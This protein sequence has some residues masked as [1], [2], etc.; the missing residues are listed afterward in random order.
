[1]MTLLQAGHSLNAQRVNFDRD[2]TLSFDGVSTD[3]RTLNVGQLFFAL[4]GPNFDGHDVLAQARDRGAVAAVVSRQVD[5]VLPQ[6]LVS[7]TRLA[8]GQLAGAWRQ[9]FKGKLIA[10]TGSNGKTTVKEMLASILACKGEVLATAGNFNNDIGMPLTLLR[11]RPEQH[12]FAVIE[13]G[14]NHRGEI[15]YLSGIAQPD[16]ALLNNAGAAHLAGFGS[17]DAVAKAKG[18]IWQ[19]LA[20]SGC[21]IINA[22]DVYSRYWQSKLSGQKTQSFG[23]TAQADVH[24]VGSVSAC[25]EQ[26]QFC[27]RF[28]MQTPQGTLSIA[29]PL[30]GQHNVMN[31]LAATAAALMVGAELADVQQGLETMTPVNGR[32]QAKKSRWGQLLIDDSYNA[33]PPSLTVA[34]DVLSQMQGEKIVVLGDMA[35]LG[36]NAASL[37]YQAGVVAQQRGIDALYGIGEFSREAVRGF[38]RGGHGF[39]SQQALIDALCEHLSKTGKGVAVLVKGS[40]SAAMDKVVTALSKVGV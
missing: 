4:N 39:E 9:Q 34:I 19:G 33:N 8:L 24:L 15:A 3:T 29:L 21:A 26:G 31:A 32:L 5:D 20:A 11:L 14:A 40:R 12:Q 13:M 6:L 35:E 22:D 10:L 16:V 18:E 25:F 38:G 28:E 36:D 27:S 23:T 37:H 1:M 17:L 7:D 30:A 2:A